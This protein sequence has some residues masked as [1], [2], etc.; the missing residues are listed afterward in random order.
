MLR[1]SLSLMLA[2]LM[3]ASV[4]FVSAATFS[5]MTSAYD[6][7]KDA[8]ETLSENGII[9]GYPEGTFKPANNITKEEAI[10]LFARTLGLSEERNETIVDLANVMF[11]DTLAEYDT[12]AKDA[13]AY[14]LYKKVLADDELDTYISASNKGKTLKRYEAATLIAKCLGGDVWLKSNPNITLS[15]SD[16]KDVPEAAKGYVYFAS[17]A[18]IIGSMDKDLNLFVPNGNV[19]RA[20]IAT[21]IYRIFN[22]MQ[23]TYTEGVIMSIT[24][25]TNTVKVR[26]EDGENEAFVVN[27]NIAV[28]V[29]GKQASIDDLKVGQD[30]VLTF[31]NDA[32]YSIDIVS[33]EDEGKSDRSHVVL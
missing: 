26:T 10:T 14:L 13:A 32:L 17:E 33:A 29:D 4:T 18:G 5:D 9:N 27:K 15:F 22:R 24:A 3:L 7:A 1:K 25:D 20:Q 11:E 23:Y 21:M 19:T 30:L 12:Y 31:S 8:V 16:A 28:M 2:V 6:W